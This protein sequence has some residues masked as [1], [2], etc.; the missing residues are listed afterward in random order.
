MKKNKYGLRVQLLAYNN[1]GNGDN[2]LLDKM[3]PC[4]IYHEG[5]VNQ[6]ME[7]VIMDAA[8]VL[9][10]LVSNG[11]VKKQEKFVL[12]LVNKYLNK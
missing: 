2:K 6:I 10:G 7:K 8:S 3:N 1:V 4:K 12:N 9:G 5:S 11:N